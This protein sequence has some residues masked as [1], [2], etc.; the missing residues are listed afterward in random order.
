M[1]IGKLTENK[2]QFEWPQQVD[3]Q[4]R[5]TRLYSPHR[6]PVKAGSG[7]ATSLGWGSSPTVMEGYAK[8]NLHGST[9]VEC[10]VALHDCRAT[11]PA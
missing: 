1:D 2:L 8:R 7:A 3:L 5:E 9:L 6:R 4:T 11:A 10:S